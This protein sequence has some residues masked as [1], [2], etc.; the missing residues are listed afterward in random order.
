MAAAF[1]YPSA[2]AFGKVL[3]KNRI[4]E[5]AKVPAR[6]KQLFVDQVERITWAYK[7]APETTNLDAGVSVTEVQVFKVVLRQKSLD[8][9][10]LRA[11]DKAVA[12]PIV[13]ELSHNG[14]LKV[15]AA[16]K[17]PS[18]SDST[19]WVVSE[20][21]GSDWGPEKNARSPLPPALDLEALY[22][23]I[24]EA[25]LPDSAVSQEAIGARVE[26]METIGRKQREVKRIEARLAREKQFNK[27]VAINAELRNAAKE[28]KRLRSAKPMEEKKGQ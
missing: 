4:Y 5:R 10:V 9:E 11:I 21:F 27:R 28:L 22:A 3:P 1:D 8:H 14:S 24:L 25:L 16:Y 6:V 15:I 17:R 18:E 12:F 13:F 2:A 19:K 20:Y 23:R 26:R 7:L